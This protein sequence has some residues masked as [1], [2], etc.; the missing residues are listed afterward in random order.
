MEHREIFTVILA[1]ALVII[2][3]GVLGM[4]SSKGN[5]NSTAEPE[6]TTERPPIT[7]QTDIWDM[8]HSQQAAMT[9]TEAP[10]PA[11]ETVTEAVIVTDEEGNPVTDEEGNPVTE[12]FVVTDEEGNPVT[13][14]AAATDEEG[15][16]ITEE[17]ETETVTDAGPAADPNEPARTEISIKLG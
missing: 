8:I 2:V 4:V 3:I 15:N 1:V 6:T 9:T 12:T 7:Q 11:D 16:L 14:T 5:E 10:E 17:T 13:G